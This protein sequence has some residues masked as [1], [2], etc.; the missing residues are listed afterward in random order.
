MARYAKDDPVGVDQVLDSVNLLVKN[1]RP[2]KA[3]DCGGGKFRV[4]VGRYR[5]WYTIKQNTPVVVAIDH[6]GRVR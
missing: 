5:V 1:P 3:Q 6:V 2:S 4:H